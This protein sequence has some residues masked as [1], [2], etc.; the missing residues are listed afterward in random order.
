MNVNSETKRKL[1]D[2]GAGDILA[3]LE[4]QHDAMCIGMTFEERMQMAVDEAHSAFVTAK[5]ENLTK[6]AQLRYPEAD[7]R[8]LDFAEERG[9]DRVTVAELAT[10]GF[11]ERCDNLVLQGFSGTGKTYMSCA[12]AKESCRHRLRAY[13][14][15]VPDLEEARRAMVAKSGSDKKLINKLANFQ[16]LVLDEWLLEKPDAEFR[17]FILEVMERRFKEGTTVFC[18]QFQQKDWH[19]RLGGGI[20]AD[21]IMDRIVHNATWIEMG[22]VNMRAKYSRAR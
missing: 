9:I 18:T 14:V 13:Y 6:R 22:D 11:V 8:T 5:I 21:A 15:R 12:L 1:R 20:H 4:A 17:A 7:V 2:M 16:M 10:C 19:A 3:A